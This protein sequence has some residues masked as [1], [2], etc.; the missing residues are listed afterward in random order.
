M[1]NWLRRLM[2]FLSNASTKKSNSSLTHPLGSMV[3]DGLT[4]MMERRLG[5]TSETTDDPRPLQ[6]MKENSE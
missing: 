2:P 3:S 1:T 6:A 4:K 5:A